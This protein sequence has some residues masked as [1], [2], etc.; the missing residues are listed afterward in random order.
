MATLTP[1][2]ILLIWFLIPQLYRYTTLLY[3]LCNPSLWI[4]PPTLTTF[5]YQFGIL[6]T[7]TLISF[8][9]FHSQIHHFLLSVWYLNNLIH[10][11]FMWLFPPFK[12]S[13][14]ERPSPSAFSL[15]GLWYLPKVVHTH[16]LV[17]GTI[18]KHVLSVVGHV[19]AMHKLSVLLHRQ[20][21][22]VGQ[23]VVPK[24]VEWKSKTRY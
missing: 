23:A 3:L 10:S 20:Q 16:T 19:E 7:Y 4:F 5:C 17:P 12:P 15:W 6:T 8:S 18:S 13:P 24:S 11:S 22:R 9:S 21:A 14:S 2:I 1:L